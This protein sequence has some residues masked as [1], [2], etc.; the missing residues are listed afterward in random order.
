M[1]EDP[2][3]GFVS[4][5]VIVI[6]AGVN[7]LVAAHVLARQGRTVLVLE[8]RATA[9]AAPASGWVPPAVI[10]ALRLTRHGLTT[11]PL[12]PWTS[13]AL[14]DG[15]RLDLG[16]DMPASMA[17]IQRLSPSDA[18]KW[19]SF[20][21]RLRRLASVL[22]DLYQQPA[23]DV[24]TTNAG[25]LFR[26]GMLG[27]K[28][29][30][31]GR[32]ATVDL[33]RV[34]P[35]SA[36]ELL[37]E[38]FESDALKAALAAG[39][40]RHLFQGPRGGGTAFSLLHHHTG[41]PAGVFRQP[42]SNIQAVLEKLPGVT[43]RR[44]A[45]VARIGVAASRVTGVTLQNGDEIAAPLVLS[46]ADPKATLVDLLEPGWL[47]PELVRAVRNIK[48]R[49]VSA[50]VTLIV[51]RPA[52]FRTL[53]VSG[54]L[55]YIE[56]AYDDAKY[57]RVS[58]RPVIEADAL[59]DRVVAAVQYVPHAPAGGWTDAAR[60]ALGETVARRL[61]EAAPGFAATVK[62]ARVEAPG[63]LAAS[64]G[65]SGGHAYHGELTLDQI[66][67]MRPVAGMSRYATPVRGLFLAGS[68]THPGG[69][70]LGG[71]GLLAAR[72]AINAY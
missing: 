62:E 21:A 3:A 58:A 55:T 15:G 31:R 26:L 45:R 72:T 18:A 68:G 11:E 32:Q 16:Q 22:E 9:D 8:Q 1:G 67:F 64:Q 7:G 54:S 48:C 5:D 60:Q 34:L 42:R 40:V 71:A 23:P 53:T 61:D 6:G 12:E 49:G 44:E 57:G 17:A 25:E 28:V 33:L 50:R 51:D 52:P 43:I 38:W 30:R 4:H 47:D 10:R 29:R 27:L 14:E 66:L 2:A 24:E 19:P 63:D 56:R 46:G 13:V 65:L 39:G 35:M 20:C 37:D 69:A 70:V 59:E 36:W 41:C